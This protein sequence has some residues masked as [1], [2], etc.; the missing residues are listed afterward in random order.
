MVEKQ[1]LINNKVGLHARP[2][3]MFVQKA[4]QFKCAIRISLGPHEVNSKSILGIL[5]LGASQGTT[6]TICAEGVDAIEAISE[7]SALFDSNF[8]EAE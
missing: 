8:G 6:I 4:S 1:F 7:L 3:S 5:S 2:A